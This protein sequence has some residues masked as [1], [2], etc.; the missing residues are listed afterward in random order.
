MILLSRFAGC[1]QKNYRSWPYISLSLIV[2]LLVSFGAVAADQHQ[3]INPEEEIRRQ[4]PGNGQDGSPKVFLDEVGLGDKESITSA[5]QS[6]LNTNGPEAFLDEIYNLLGNQPIAK[7]N[8]RNMELADALGVLWA[9]NQG[10]NAGIKE[11]TA[12]KSFFNEHRTAFLNNLSWLFGES[13]VGGDLPEH[14]RYF[15]EWH[16]GSGSWYRNNIKKAGRTGVVGWNSALYVRGGGDFTLYTFGLVGC[17]AI[18]AEADDGSAYMAHAEGDGRNVDS[19]L[20]RI[21]EQLRLFSESRRVVRLRT[22]GPYAKTWSENFHKEYPAVKE[23]GWL[24]PEG[25]QFS[26]VN[27]VRFRRLKETVAV[28]FVRRPLSKEYLGSIYPNTGTMNANWKEGEY[29]PDFGFVGGRSSLI[30]PSANL[31]FM[32]AFFC[33]DANPKCNG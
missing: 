8:A 2:L 13:I 23:I 25:E 18:F 4:P 3:R 7:V 28:D 16:F 17:T 31:P 21:R 22:L 11:S 12:P 20:T 9:V 10:L 14:Q 32:R 15:L 30:F 27:T 1:R 6:Y 24:R 29:W 19:H 26:Y 33:S 5:V